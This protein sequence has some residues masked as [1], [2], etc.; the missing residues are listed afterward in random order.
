[1]SNLSNFTVEESSTIEKARNVG[2][3]ENMSS[4]SIP[5]HDIRLRP[6]HTPSLVIRFLTTST[7][8]PRS[9]RISESLPTHMDEFE[10]M[11]KEITRP[12]T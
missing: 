1:M 3:Y 4:E 10:K 6:K 9:R 7:Q 2:D 8:R 5:I 11:E 12:I